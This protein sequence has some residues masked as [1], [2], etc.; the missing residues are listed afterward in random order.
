MFLQQFIL[1]LLEL[2]VQ[3]LQFHKCLQL[4]EQN[5]QLERFFQLFK[6]LRKLTHVNQSKKSLLN[7]IIF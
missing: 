2:S 5:Y 3:V 7:K 6:S 4:V 1:C